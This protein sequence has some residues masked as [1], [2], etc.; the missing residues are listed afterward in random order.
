MVKLISDMIVW[1]RFETSV[2]A[3][4]FDRLL[5]RIRLTISGALQWSS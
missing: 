1:N 5:R 3:R 4:L 2:M